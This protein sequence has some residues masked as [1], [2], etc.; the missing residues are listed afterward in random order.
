M[1]FTQGLHPLK[2]ECQPIPQFSA[3][4]PSSLLVGT[5][6]FLCFWRYCV[7]ARHRLGLPNGWTLAVIFFFYHI[8]LH[9]QVTARWF[10]FFRANRY[11]PD[12]CDNPVHNHRSS[13]LSN[14][15]LP[16]SK[17][18]QGAERDCSMIVTG[19]VLIQRQSILHGLHIYWWQYLEFY[20]PW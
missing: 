19:H 10:A 5:V 2:G 12:Y 1:S 13:N 16:C 4:A 17:T 11:S 6:Y 3:Q 18:Q 7:P 15:H 9:G 14:Q 20:V 8:P